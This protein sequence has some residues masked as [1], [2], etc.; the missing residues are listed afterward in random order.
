MNK[1]NVLTINDRFFFESFLPK[2]ASLSAYSFAY[3]L[4]WSDI[5]HYSWK[6]VDHNFCLIA[7]NG[8]EHYMPLPP[9]PEGCD[10]TFAKCLGLLNSLNVHSDISRI[11]NVPE[12]TAKMLEASGFS[13]EFKDEEYV[14]ERESLVEL[15]GD[16][17]KHI[18]WLCNTFEKEHKYSIHAY[19]E[20]FLEPCVELLHDWVNEKTGKVSKEYEQFLLN[21]TLRSHKRVLVEH[22]KLGLSG[23]VLMADDRVIAYTFGAPLG[24]DTFCIFMEVADHTIKGAQQMIFREFCAEM[25]TFRYINAMADE[26]IESLKASKEHY[27]PARKEREYTVTAKQH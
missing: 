15:K 16:K 7:K 2:K 27:H 6:I 1:L 24:K 12:L 20:K 23:R 19:K 10:V 22:D 11:D 9:L 13:S 14:Y 3:H 26:G 21:H 17:Y 4:M 5:T 18:R 8:R 25:K